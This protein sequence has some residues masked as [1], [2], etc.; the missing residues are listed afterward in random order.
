MWI[1]RVVMG[2]AAYDLHVGVGITRRIPRQAAGDLHAAS[3]IIVKVTANHSNVI[4]TSLLSA[5]EDPKDAEP[6]HVHILDAHVLESFKI[7]QAVIEK[8]SVAEVVRWAITHHHQ[9]ADGDAAGALD[10]DPTFTTRQKPGP[11]TSKGRDDHWR[12]GSASA[13]P[14]QP[15]IPPKLLV[16][17]E[18]NAVTWQKRTRADLPD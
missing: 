3:E 18:Q 6:T 10:G 5:N 14:V 13:L 15:Q 17:L 7:I 2:L 1:A 8:H 16:A 12:I 9:V 11:P 4:E